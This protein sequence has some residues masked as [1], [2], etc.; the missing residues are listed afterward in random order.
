MMYKY[1]E[2]KINSNL[3]LSLIYIFS[4]LCVMATTLTTNPELVNLMPNP[5]K[6]IDF[7]HQTLLTIK[8]TLNILQ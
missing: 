4:Y 6:F 3:K 8:K 7:L 2:H 5:L 1:Y